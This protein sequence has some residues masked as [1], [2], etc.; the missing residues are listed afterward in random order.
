MTNIS[1]LTNQLDVIWQALGERLTSNFAEKLLDGAIRVARSDNPI[2][3]NLFASA[4]REL[5]SHSLRDFA[6]DKNVKASQWFKVETCDERPTRRQRMKYAVQGGIS[7]SY[8][9]DT[10]GL[11]FDDWFKEV[12]VANDELNKATHLQPD[13]IITHEADVIDLATKSAEAMHRLLDAIGSTREGLLNAV[14]EQLNREA[15]DAILAETVQTIDSLAPHHS[16]EEIW[17]DDIR[18]T[19]IDSEYV[20]YLV[21]GTIEAELRW[22]SNSDFRKGDGAAA[23]HSFPFECDMRASVSSPTDLLLDELDLRVSRGNWNSDAD[24]YFE[25]V[26]L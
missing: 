8:L 22:G 11:V 2:R 26:K 6:P 19:K 20:W 9:H 7:D 24:E 25:E 1:P 18:V 10:L 14:E 13:T 5:L 21:A 15:I 12:I 16:I 17:A 4:F 3:G 23:N